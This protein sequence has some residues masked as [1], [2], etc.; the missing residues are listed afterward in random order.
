MIGQDLPSRS[1]LLLY[2]R[3]CFSNLKIKPFHKCN[4]VMD[5]TTSLVVWLSAIFFF[6][7]KSSVLSFIV[8]LMS[9]LL[10]VCKC[11]CCIT[12]GNMYIELFIISSKDEMLL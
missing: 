12:R 6:F 1:A 8:S 4:V 3:E 11:H 7:I 10:F 9:F 2:I 5:C